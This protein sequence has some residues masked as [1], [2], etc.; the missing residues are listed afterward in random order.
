MRNN[1]FIICVTS[2]WKDLKNI[3]K[4]LSIINRS[5]LAEVCRN[6]TKCMCQDE[7]DSCNKSMLP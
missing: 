1:T 7:A 3:I 6:W 5:L 2:W 4:C